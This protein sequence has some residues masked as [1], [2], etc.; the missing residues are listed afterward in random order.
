MRKNKKR[1]QWRSII[2]QQQESGIAVITFC[3][4]HQLS[5]SAFY[6]NRAKLFPELTQPKSFISTQ[7]MPKVAIPQDANV[8]FILKHADIEL[9]IPLTTSP[10][11]IV[12]L[13]R[14]MT[15]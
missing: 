13:I 4:E 5:T 6:H 12:R 11:L 3:R 2:L 15:R 8:A 14:E 10:E 1:K 7:L 9:S